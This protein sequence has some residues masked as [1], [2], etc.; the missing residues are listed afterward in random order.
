MLSTLEGWFC[1]VPFPFP[2]AGELGKALEQLWRMEYRSALSPVRCLFLQKVLKGL[3]GSQHTPSDLCVQLCWLWQQLSS[4]G[5][6]PALPAQQDPLLSAPHCADNTELSWSHS[7]DQETRM[8]PVQLS[9]SCH[10]GVPENA[11]GQAGIPLC[12]HSKDL[13]GPGCARWDRREQ[14]QPRDI[15][16][17]LGD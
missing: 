1:T 13:E 15:P 10:S 12:V 5:P 2:S 3:P 4:P 9:F 6:A 16:V 14:G 7:W 17:L 8:A 11:P